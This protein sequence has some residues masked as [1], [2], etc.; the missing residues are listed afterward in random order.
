M[1]Y[2][3]FIDRAR[4]PSPLATVTLARQ[5]A[6]RF[7]LPAEAIS[8]R[9]AK[10]PFRVKSGVDLPT[11]ERFAADLESLGAVCSIVDD[12]TNQPVARARSAAPAL[13]EQ[14]ALAQDDAD[15]DAP[16][17][18]SSAEDYQSGLAAAFGG[19]AAGSQDIGALGDADSGSFSL[20]TIDG[21]D[22]RDR[23]PAVAQSFSP[24]GTDEAPIADLFAPPES[25]EELALGIDTDAAPA[26]V[27][28]A[29]AAPPARE[30][31]TLLPDGA[32]P[33]V[34]RA[35]EGN[36]IQRGRAA[37]AQR[38]GVRA[39]VGAMLAML[40]GFAVA[41]VVG[42]VRESSAFDAPLENIAAADATYAGTAVGTAAE[43]AELTA[44]FQ[45]QRAAQL[46]I[47]EDSKQGIAILAGVIWLLVAGGVG[48]VWWRVIDWDRWA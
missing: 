23:A 21:A 44:A 28:R 37:L 18:S 20:A 5:I 31:L 25:Q 10:G 47:M 36:P 8:A 15:G 9:L 32:A 7:Q 34:P 40:L 2:Q 6:E 1:G 24:P 46:A 17:G 43:Q 19:G 26:A 42:T 33:T 29:P 12:V 41:H 38:P 3:V 13:E 27:A 16:I 30:L 35:P 11:A 4:D 45:K 14:P 39:A 48:Y 22:D